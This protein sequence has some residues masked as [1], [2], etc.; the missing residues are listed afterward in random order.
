ME[1]TEVDRRRHRINGML[2]T[3]EQEVH[4]RSQQG[5]HNVEWEAIKMK[6]Q[7][8]LGN[9]N[10]NKSLEIKED[11]GIQNKGVR[12]EKNMDMDISC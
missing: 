9:G 1:L 12:G 5:R 2:H 11:V 8:K 3:G 6:T 10:G 4:G 7:R